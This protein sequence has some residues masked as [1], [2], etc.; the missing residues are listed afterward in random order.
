MG[1][2]TRLVVVVEN[3]SAEPLDLVVAMPYAQTSTPGLMTG[4]VGGGV[5]HVE[6]G[7]GGTWSSARPRSGQRMARTFQNPHPVVVERES[8]RRSAPAPAGSRATEILVTWE[9]RRVR[10]VFE[11]GSRGWG[12][13]AQLAQ[14]EDV[15][16]RELDVGV[17]QASRD[18]ERLMRVWAR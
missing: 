2:T 13:A 18:L 11:A 17:T 5:F 6:L 10:L 12:Y 1:C 7:P 16:V 15:E 14:G 3:R 4:A 9:D 8:W